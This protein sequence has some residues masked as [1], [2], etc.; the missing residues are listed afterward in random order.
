[1]KLEKCYGI[2]KKGMNECGGKGT[3]HSCQGQSKVDGAPNEWMLVLKGTCKKI[4]GGNT[5]P[6]WKK[7]SD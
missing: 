2:G 5:E 3:G 7:K 4:V 1:V 6:A